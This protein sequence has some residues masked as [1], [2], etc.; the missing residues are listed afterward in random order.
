MSKYKKLSSYFSHCCWMLHVWIHPGAPLHPAGPPAPA[1]WWELAAGTAGSRDG[2][3]GSR[4][5]WSPAPLQRGRHAVSVKRLIDN[6]A[7]F[8]SWK[9]IKP[10]GK[11][12]VHQNNENHQFLPTNLVLNY[13]PDLHQVNQ[14][15]HCFIF[16][17]QL[18]GETRPFHCMHK[19]APQKLKKCTAYFVAL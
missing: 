9:I 3:C 18:Y 15:Q 4:P 12:K 7:L 19:H 5:E 1:P 10:N 8:L 16:P 6:A 13:L 11:N 2:H 17:S 14:K